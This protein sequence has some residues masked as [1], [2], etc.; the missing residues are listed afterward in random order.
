MRRL[1]ERARELKSE[2]MES[3]SEMKETLEKQMEQHREQHHRQLAELR[4]E[5]A[6]K[7]T[8]IDEL[9]ESV[10]MRAAA[11]TGTASTLRATLYTLPVIARTELSPGK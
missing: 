5:I 11:S 4:Q 8:R 1:E 3:A 6:D 10:L 2:L 9:A 7:Q